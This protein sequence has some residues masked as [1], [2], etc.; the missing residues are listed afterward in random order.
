MIRL[1]LTRV[2]RAFA[3][4]CP[5]SFLFLFLVIYVG[6][7][8]ERKSSQAFFESLSRRDWLVDG[9]FFRLLLMFL[10]RCYSLEPPICSPLHCSGLLSLFKSLFPSLALY[11][12]SVVTDLFL[13]SSPLIFSL[14]L[15]FFSPPF[16]SLPPSPSLPLANPALVE[17]FSFCVPLMVLR[18][19]Y[20]SPSLPLYLKGS[21]S[22]HVRLSAPSLSVFPLY[23]SP[24]PPLR[25]FSIFRDM[26]ISIARHSVTSIT[27]CL[28]L[29]PVGVRYDTKAIILSSSRHHLASLG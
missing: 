3:S 25:L 8:G 14:S 19:F 5:F 21:L 24:T 16:H 11:C 9:R 29:H 6:T 7:V 28:S 4:S 15:F 18:L 10:L 22:R 20:N 1:L 17:S 2:F 26:M 27:K 23:P 12:P 13:A